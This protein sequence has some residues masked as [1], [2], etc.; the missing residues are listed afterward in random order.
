MGGR[1]SAISPKWRRHFAHFPLYELSTT[2]VVGLEVGVVRVL[3][4]TYSFFEAIQ[5]KLREKRVFS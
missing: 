1:K 4:G 3:E 5:F 2:F